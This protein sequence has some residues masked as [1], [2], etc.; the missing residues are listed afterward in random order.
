MSS[1]KQGKMP[2]W[3]Q[4]LLQWEQ[5][6]GHTMLK[7]DLLWEKLQEKLQSRRRKKAV[8]IFRVAAAVL[9]L[10]AVSLVFLLRKKEAV[11]KPGLVKIVAPTNPVKKEPVHI[12]KEKE[13]ISAATVKQDVSPVKNRKEVKDISPALQDDNSK[14]VVIDPAYAEATAGNLKPVPPV[15]EKPAE[16]AAGKSEPVA[17]FVQPKRKLRIVHLNELNAPP[18]PT[19]ATAKDEWI[20]SLE[21]EEE[22]TVPSSSVWP[23]KNKY[24]PSISLGN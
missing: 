8:H 23:G 18:P 22:I 16:A 17:T 6:G 14:E 7:D 11:E 2:E 19:Y 24:K 15:I 10:L 9:I 20:Q 5:S 12:V 4:T 1:E 21:K 13:E 3:K